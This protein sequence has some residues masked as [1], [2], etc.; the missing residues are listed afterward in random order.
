[1]VRDRIISMIVADSECRGRILH[2]NP[3]SIDVEI[4]APWNGISQGLSIPYFAC[5]GRPA[6]KFFEHD[7]AF[8]QYGEFIAELLLRKLNANCDVVHK[9]RERLSA[10]YRNLRES[11]PEQCPDDEFQ[12]LQ[13]ECRKHQRRRLKDELISPVEYQRQLQA[14]KKSRQARIDVNFECERIFSRHIQT[15]HGL[16]IPFDTLRSLIRKFLI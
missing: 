3:R 10:V 4:T 5:L 13:L 9:N 15:A 7:A 16:V 8:T 1:M 14:L 6:L 11:L 12:T 2:L